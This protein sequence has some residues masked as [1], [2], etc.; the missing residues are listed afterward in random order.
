MADARFLS[1]FAP[2]ALH[3]FA[4]QAAVLL[5]GRY[6]GTAEVTA[7]TAA[8]LTPAA[9]FLYRREIA[10]N[11]E[12]EKRKTGKLELIGAALLGIAA[13]QILTWML[14]AGG[15]ASYFSNETQ[16][17]LFRGKL[18]VQILG[19]GVFVPIAEEL[20]FRGLTYQRIKRMAGI[21]PGI[22]F[23]SA[24][25]AVYHGNV[26]QMLYAFPMA[27]LLC[28]VYEKCDS[29]KGPI[30]VHMAANLTAVILNEIR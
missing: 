22:L 8:L 15:V 16:Q 12:R 27:I 3:F 1:V 14:N 2:M 6:C 9:I 25:F 23:S 24:L 5:F 4:S 30:T 18:S 11:Q 29:I 17:E 28:A 21:K 19:S 7:L 13:S 10:H 26:I 20:L